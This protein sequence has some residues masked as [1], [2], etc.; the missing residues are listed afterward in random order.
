VNVAEKI[1]D[2]FAEY[3]GRHVFMV[4]GGH[5]MYLNEA[6]S[7]H[8]N[9]EVVSVLHEQAGAIACEA[10]Y[11]ANGRMAMLLVTAGPGVTNAL[12]GVAGAYLDAI[13]MLVVSGQ[14]K[15]EERPT[16]RPRWAPM[17][18]TTEVVRPVTRYAV[19]VEAATVNFDV[20]CALAVANETK[21]PSWLDVPLDVQATEL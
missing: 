18:P 16:S 17:L 8:P 2:V 14:I 6:A 21:A 3:G 19:T 13:P 9:L 7:V 20:T 4:P 1:M 11:R 10:Y 15:T 5:A 12:T